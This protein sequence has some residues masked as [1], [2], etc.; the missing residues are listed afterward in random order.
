MPQSRRSTQSPS[1]K[2][3]EM[4]ANMTIFLAYAPVGKDRNAFKP[5]KNNNKKKGRRRKDESDT[6]NPSVYPMLV[7]SSDVDPETIVS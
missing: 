6:L 5:K 1:A 7:F 2:K 3:E 4:N